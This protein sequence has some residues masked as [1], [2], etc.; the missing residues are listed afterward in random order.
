MVQKLSVYMQSKRVIIMIIIKIPVRRGSEK[1]N[2]D[3]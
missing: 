2:K 3:K 1:D